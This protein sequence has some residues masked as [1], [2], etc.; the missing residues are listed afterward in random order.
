M[1]STVALILALLLTGCVAPVVID[2]RAQTDFSQYHSYAFDPPKEDQEA[3]S[4]DG[5]RVQTAVREALANS[6]LQP[7][8]ESSADLLVRY[9]FVPVDRF[10]A[11]SVQFG[12][13]FWRDRYGLSTT[14]PV[15]GQTNQEYRLQIAL[16][17]R[18]D[19]QVVWQGT[20]RDTLYFEM[21]T[22]RRAERIDTMVREMFNRYPPV[23][24]PD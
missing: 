24:T 8:D 20:S 3:L 2:Q 12:F 7:A 13:G 11:S 18:G 4:L 9:R 1:R 17:D 23:A 19:K 10:Q 14:T 22:E 21:A 5:Q 16:V 15:E 6:P